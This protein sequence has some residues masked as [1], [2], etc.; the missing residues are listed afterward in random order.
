MSDVEK[1]G[2]FAVV[3]VGGLLLVI[4][5]QGGFGGE[6][7]AA[8]P[9][10]I[11]SG[12]PLRSSSTSGELQVSPAVRIKPIL[13]DTPF[14]WSEGGVQYPGERSSGAAPGVLAAPPAAP[15]AGAGAGTGTHAIAKGETL[16]DVAAK[17]LGSPSKWEQLVAWNPGLDPRRLQ[18]GQVIR[19]TPGAPAAAQ[20]APASTASTPAASARP[21]GARTHTVV[22]GDTLGGIARKYLGSATKAAEVYEANK[23]VLK[24]MDDLKIGQTLIIP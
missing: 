20:A 17:Y 3:L 19:V 11:D 4:A 18:I 21:S 9:E 15:A 7:A 24:S 2:L 6:E 16:S 10:V 1:Y 23:Q 5:M 13:P 12:T 8:L 14:T 22:K